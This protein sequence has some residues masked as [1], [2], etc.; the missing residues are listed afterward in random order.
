MMQRGGISLLLFAG[1]AVAAIVIVVF[2]TAGINKAPAPSPTPADIQTQQL[3]EQG[4]S[5]E[6]ASIEQDLEAT[7]FTSLDVELSD[8]D[9]ELSR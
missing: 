3:M 4:E 7:E 6:T 8:I 9:K 5:D 1:A 2:A